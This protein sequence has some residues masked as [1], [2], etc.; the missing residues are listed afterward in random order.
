VLAF[1]TTPI[2]WP[3]KPP[4]VVRKDELFQ[5]QADPLYTATVQATEEAIVNAL[6]AARTMTGLN[7]SRLH[8][9]PHDRLRD[10][11]RR[12]KRLVE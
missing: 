2:K 9:L 5:Y 8:A 10:V 6:V 4:Y 1:A 12:Y 7:G 11:L 3:E